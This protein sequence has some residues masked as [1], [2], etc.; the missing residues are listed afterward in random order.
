MST[1]TATSTWS[2]RTLGRTADK[3]DSV[4]LREQDLAL[5]SAELESLER[6]FRRDFASGYIAET[7][8]KLRDRL[9]R[10]YAALLGR[11]DYPA[12][13][14][15]APW[16]SAFIES[17]GE[18]RPCFFQPSLGNLRKAGSLLSILNS[19]EAIRWRRRL[20]TRSDEICRKCVCSLQLTGAESREQSSS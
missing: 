9:H 12:V 18:V 1:V 7:P 16:V 2:L 6:R 8:Q 17:D 19:P 10:Y 13:S 5:L 15:N 11:N 3:T 4:A 20:D 14:C